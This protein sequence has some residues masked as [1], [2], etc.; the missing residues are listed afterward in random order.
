MKLKTTKLYYNPDYK[1][2]LEVP[3]HWTVKPS[4][5]R[6]T[7][8][9]FVYRESAT[10]IAVLGVETPPDRG[11]A[12][13][14]DEM[15]A[16]FKHEFPDSTSIRLDSGTANID[17]IDAVWNIV[18]VTDPPEARIIGKHYYFRR[19]KALLRLTAMTDSG[20]EFFVAALPALEEVIASLK[21]EA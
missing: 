12:L 19:G 1:F 7:A 10:L 20:S 14:P 21:F 8:V 5:Q 9:K 15:F 4:A 11:A 2:T 3:L 18:E 6:D 17:G 16:S 13:S